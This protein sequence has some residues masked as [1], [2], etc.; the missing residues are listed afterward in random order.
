MHN[1]K[2]KIIFYLPY[3]SNYIHKKI[4]FM[5]VIKIYL[6]ESIYFICVYVCVHIYILTEFS[7]ILRIL[8]NTY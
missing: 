4:G 5:F 1:I 8:L 7:E 2:A 3:I 6:G